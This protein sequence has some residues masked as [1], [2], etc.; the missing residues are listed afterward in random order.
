V[1]TRAGGLGV[2]MVGAN[3]VVLFDASWNPS[4]DMQS[5][6]RV[7]RFGQ[8][9]PCYIYRFLAAGTMEEKI[10]DRQ[11]TKLALS[12]RVVD[13]HTIDRHYTQADLEELYSFEPYRENE[14]TM[15][16]PKVIEDFYLGQWI[17]LW[18][19]FIYFKDRLLAELY[20]KHKVLVEEYFE[21]DSLLEDRPDE[22]LTEE[23]QRA[24]WDEFE[25]EKELLVQRRKGAA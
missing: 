15:I 2:N 24:A 14:K 16:F 19:V 23:E 4:S 12:G 1:S 7:Y 25:N 10:Y 9:K 5:I 22:N 17:V 13:K 11:V 20:Q 3:R 18:Y 8:M 6:F 21:H